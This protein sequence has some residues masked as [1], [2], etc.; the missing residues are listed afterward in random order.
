M[1]AVQWMLAMF[2]RWWLFS[3]CWPCSVDGGCSVDVGH[4]QWM[5]AVLG[6][7]RSSLL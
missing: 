2:S 5:L 7:V 1:V 3:G 4:V 6:V